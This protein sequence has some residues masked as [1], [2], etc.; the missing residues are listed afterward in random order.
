MSRVITAI[1]AIAVT[2]ALLAPTEISATVTVTTCRGEPATIVGEAGRD[3][4]GTPGRDVVITNR[5]QEVRTLEG[6]DLVCVTGPDSP[7]DVSHPVEVDL[8]PGDDVLDGT[9]A[10]S[11]PV[12]ATLG[13]GAD[14]FEGGSGDDDVST[15]AFEPT[16]YDHL[17][18]EEDVVRAGAGR[19]SVTSGEVGRSNHDV[20][21]LDA[22]PDSVRWS[23]TWGGGSPIDG[24]ADGA[25]LHT[26]TAA[27]A[28]L[29]VPAGELQLGTAPPLVFTNVHSFLLVVD[30]PGVSMGVVG[31]P[32]TDH[33]AVWGDPLTTVTAGLGAGDDT[34]A[35]LRAPT[36]A[37]QLDAGS[38]TDELHLGSAEH[39]LAL[40][41]ASGE[42]RIGETVS[43]AP[44]FENAQLL[45][46][47]VDLAGTPKDN[48][49]IAVGCRIELHG[50]GGDDLMRHTIDWDWET[51]LFGCDGRLTASGGGGRDLIDGHTG[52]DRIEAGAG[53]DEVLGGGGADRIH[54]G[55]GADTLD[56]RGAGDVVLGGAGRDRLSGGTGKDRLAGGRG[57]D[58]ADG[59]AGRDR[60]SAEHR[61]RCEG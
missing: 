55:G 18:A 5:S 22:G 47:E 44:S 30:G 17:D 56:G 28:R 31:T 58:R 60:C 48:S 34:M 38:G 33:I 16:S 53:R 3:I 7:P 61:T 4:I 11:W 20:L 52:N 26:T 9:A 49:L 21:Q 36:S 46:E 1:S 57:A 6:D 12:Q 59:G 54:G 23:G 42:L 35:L 41:L 8:G 14:L 15:G 51:Y 45:A 10:R 32:G 2:C 27:P 13:P 37:S 25:L 50:R 24:G 19:D 39:P 43:A 40:D 29:D